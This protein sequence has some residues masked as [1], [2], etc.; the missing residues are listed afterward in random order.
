MGCTPS[1]ALKRIKKKAVRRAHTDL[2]LVSKEVRHH[3]FDSS[4]YERLMTAYSMRTGFRR[5]K[6]DDHGGGMRL[7][8]IHLWFRGLLP[9][10]SKVEV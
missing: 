10:L 6:C 4:E 9:K 8:L 5:S 1:T 3:T 7:R 2:S